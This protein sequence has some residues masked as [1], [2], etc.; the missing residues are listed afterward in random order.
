MPVVETPTAQI[1]YTV[2]GRG[3]TTL[4]MLMGLGGSSEEWGPGFAEALTLRF[5]VVR[6]DNRG[7]PPSTNRAPSFTMGD[8]ANDAVAVLDAVGTARAHVLGLSMGGMIAQQLALDHPLRV[9]RL[10]LVSTHFGG[11][12]LARMQ[13]RAEPLFGPPP[14]GTTD[15]ALFRDV[16]SRITAPGFAER[17][18]ELAERFT[19]NR[20]QHRVAM[21][22]FI[23]QIQ[24]IMGSDRSQ[25]L[26]RLP[27]PTLVIH[28]KDDPLI[29]L[30]NG[31]MLAARIPNAS[32]E[33][34]PDCGHLPN[35]EYPRQVIDAVSRFLA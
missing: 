24:A 5:R 28:G 10:V 32:L 31:R 27:H 17:H 18:P 11:R 25:A 22:V 23:L 19:R 3:P 30:E 16:F 33:E 34:L 2:E 7:V 21:A 4:L 9:D 1:H 13:P 14:P 35:W 6:L 29:V 15:E 20:L 26:S 12:E 8:M